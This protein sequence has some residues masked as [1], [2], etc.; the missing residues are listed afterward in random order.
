[1]DC[2]VA[3]KDW[4]ITVPSRWAITYF[5]AVMTCVMLMFPVPLPPGVSTSRIFAPGAI[6]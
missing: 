3:T 2:S 4:L 5:S 1:M 6:V